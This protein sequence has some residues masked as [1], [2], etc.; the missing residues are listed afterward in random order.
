MKGQAMPDFLHGSSLLE[1][2]SKSVAAS[3]AG[4]AAGSGVAITVTAVPQ[5][6]RFN[7]LYPTLADNEQSCLPESTDTVADLIALGRVMD[8]DN[9][10]PSVDSAIPSIHTYFGQFVAHDITWERTTE[11]IQLDNNL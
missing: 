7:F 9:S 11:S 5:V 6:T 8:E 4:T 2:Q 1:E 10:Q 3:A